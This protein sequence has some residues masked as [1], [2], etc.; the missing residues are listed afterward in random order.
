M[1][2]AL[3]V[4]VAA[5][6]RLANINLAEVKGDEATTS[7][8]VKGLVQQGKVPL[9]G[10][11]LSTGGNAGPIYYYILLIPFLVSFNPIVASSFVAIVNVLGI[12]VTFKFAQ[13]FFNDRV[14]LIAT[15]LDAVSPFAILFS[16]KIWNPDLI[17]PFSAV[18]FYCL[19][20]FVIKNKPKYLIPLFVTYSIML[21]VHPITL[22]LAPVLLLFLIQSHSR[23]S[24]RYLVTSVALSLII[25]AP[26]IYGEVTSSLSN[27]GAF[28][29]TLR[30][31]AAGINPTVVMLLS[32]V[33]S[34]V[35]FDYIL[36][37]SS[38][39]F[40]GSILHLNS[41]FLVEDLC[42]YLG[43][44][45]VLLR[46][47]RKPFHEGLRYS[48][49]FS[50]IAFPTLIL[51]FFHPTFGLLPHH[52]VMFLPANFLV[53]AILFDSALAHQSALSSV[54]KRRLKHGPK[55][56]RAAFLAV[57]ISILLVQIIFEVGFLNFLSTNGGTAGDYQVGVQYKIDVASYIAQNSN[58]SAFTIS[59]N[60]IP[61][62]IG[63][64]YYY[65][66]S[67]YDKTPSIFADLNYVI[68]NK[69][70]NVSSLLTQQLS[71]DPKVG[72]GPLTV[73]TV[74]E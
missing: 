7:F 36:G 45:L 68:I 33:T 70:A 73:Y 44:A 66:L 30:L 3:I 40:Y 8:V 34:G 27:T 60:L 13:E 10:P 54:L 25:F 72:F 48:I 59:Y 38:G 55:L 62:Q 52:V 15:A 4:M 2:F 19:Y 17:F 6:F 20:S 37:A 39:S 74:K 1:L 49:L 29:S 16:R 24:A 43:L 5:Y 51:L 53:I 69:L 61:G 50:W 32:S 67:L 12:I 14:A 57:L 64:E 23:I 26:L 41:F 21:Q 22:F 28:I 9:L 31:F 63:I 18:L 42:L 35:G 11:P 47:A 46:A 56:A 71:G 65:L 58:G